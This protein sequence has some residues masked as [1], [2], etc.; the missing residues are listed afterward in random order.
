MLKK[1]ICLLAGLVLLASASIAPAGG[2][3]PQA[4]QP[5]TYG[6]PCGPAPVP[7]QDPCAYWG[8]A[9]FPGICGGVVGLPFLVVGSLLGGNPAGPCGPPPTPANYCAPPAP[10]PAAKPYYY[11]PPPPRPYYYGPGYSSLG[12]FDTIPGMEIAS[13]IIGSVTGSAGLLY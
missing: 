6:K 9:P 13:G 4:P 7:G 11:P 2:P 5:Y 1:G 10:Y 12:L 8:D 3:P